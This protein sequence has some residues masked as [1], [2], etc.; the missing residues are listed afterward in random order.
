MNS[1]FYTMTGE[2]DVI[3]LQKESLNNVMISQP[4]FKVKDIFERCLCKLLGMSSI[5]QLEQEDYYAFHKKWIDEGLECEVL[6]LGANQWKKG[7]VRIKVTVE[8]CPD[9]SEIIEP[10]SPLDDI[11]REI[12]QI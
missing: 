2:E 10:E 7:K 1:K 3:S 11:R 9:E 12:K 4:M 6:N 8:F 5:A